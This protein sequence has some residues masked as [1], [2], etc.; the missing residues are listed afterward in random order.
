M[1]GPQGQNLAGHQIEV[2]LPICFEAVAVEEARQGIR[3][4][5]IEIP[6]IE[7]RIRD[8]SGLIEDA[9]ERH[10]MR[11]PAGKDLLIALGTLESLRPQEVIP[12]KA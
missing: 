1:F 12:G 11:R 10:Q 9:I 6:L 5:R 7:F 3:S 8:P 2:P 4:V